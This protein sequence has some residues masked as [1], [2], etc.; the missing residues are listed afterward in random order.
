MDPGDRKDVEQCA[1][2]P[3][4]R[5]GVGHVRPPIGEVRL[6]LLHRTGL[7]RGRRIAVSQMSIGQHVASSHG[8]SYHCLSSAM[9]P[10]AGDDPVYIHQMD[11]FERLSIAR[12]LIFQLSSSVNPWVT[13]VRL[14]LGAASEPQLPRDFRVFAPRVHQGHTV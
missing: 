9:A 14:H 7:G 1:L 13:L 10:T 5:Q 3:R 6:P 11:A 2:G 8:L 12:P 4:G